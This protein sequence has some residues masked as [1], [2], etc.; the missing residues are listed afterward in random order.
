MSMLRSEFTRAPSVM[1]GGLRG[2]AHLQGT[3]LPRCVFRVPRSRSAAS[4]QDEAW[5]LVDVKPTKLVEFLVDG[6]WYPGDLRAWVKLDGRWRGD[7]TYTVDV[8]MRK[9]GWF[10]EDRLRP[11]T[12]ST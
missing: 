11:Y 2:V 3:H 7:V 9:L 6:T 8:G 5:A 1:A 12:A 10:F 4:R